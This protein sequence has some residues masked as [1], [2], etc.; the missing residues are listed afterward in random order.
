[1]SSS[2]LPLPRAALLSAALGSLALD[3]PV[4]LAAQTFR[5]AVELVPISA[6]VRDGR[7]RLVTSLKAGDFE[8]VD[9]GERRPILDFQVDR[10]SPVAV[11]LLMDISGSMRVHPRQALAEQTAERILAGL[12]E[13]RDEAALFTFDL[14]LREV[15]AFTTDTA[16]IGPYVRGGQPFGTTSLYDAI[17]A[18]ARLVAERPWPRRAVIVLTD[19]LDT[20]STLTAPE[21]SGL[22]SSIDVP[23][24]VV[25]TVPPLD[26]TQHEGR[27][28][29]ATLQGADLRDL[30]QWTGGDLLWT[31]AESGA[32][33]SA[34][35]VLAELRQQYLIA[36]ESAP[37][38]EWRPL[39]VRVKNRRLS[40][41][42]RSGYFGRTP[43]PER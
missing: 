35:Q 6:I 39:E 2:L 32:E 4:P 29:V 20:S 17:A 24:Y 27:A 5:S 43:A 31:T 38:R 14:R 13:G 42:A 18:T 12:Y 30:A 26:R 11:A 28:G 21:V 36:I 9:K 37:G 15:Q 1:M 7:G 8:V 19:G 10:A 16:A 40:V 22:A 34:Q 33:A 41:R 3:R 25:V 23:V